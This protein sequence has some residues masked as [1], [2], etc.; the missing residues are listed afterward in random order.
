M[1]APTPQ[2]PD[3]LGEL[4]ALRGIAAVGVVAYHAVALH[5][6]SREIMWGLFCS[7]LFPLVTGRPFVLLFFVLSGFVLH[8]ALVAER[9]ARGSVNVAAFLAKRHGRNR[10]SV[11][12]EDVPP[13]QAARLA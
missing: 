10:L 2:R 9:E 3:R 13:P 8:A 1:S 11:Y 5:P 4:D 12:G 7:P 6:P